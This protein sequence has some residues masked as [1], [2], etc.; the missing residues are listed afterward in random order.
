[1]PTLINL[2]G[3]KFSRLL[4]IRQGAHIGGYVRWTCRCDCGKKVDVGTSRLRSGNTK[5]CG[6][7]KNERIGALNRIV[8]PEQTFWSRVDRQ[9]SKKVCWEWLGK[10]NNSGYGSFKGAGAH[11]AAYNFEIGS[12]KGMCVLHKCD[13]RKCCNPA[14]LFLGTKS[15][16]SQDAWKKGRN[17]FQTHPTKRPRGEGHKNAKLTSKKVATI[18]RKYATGKHKQIDLAKMYGS[19]QA[20][21]SQIIRN[22]S[23]AQ[24]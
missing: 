3:Q 6:C 17:Y 7:Y 16:N 22:V 21:I 24:E 5:S 12:P 11:V 4:V 2:K 18:R 23:W 13:N 20:G 14:H 1:M 15:D 9:R 10:T 8:S 19:T